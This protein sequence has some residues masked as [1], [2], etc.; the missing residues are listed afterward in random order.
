[1]S[2]PSSAL[3]IP[4]TPWGFSASHVPLYHEWMSSPE[5]REATASEELSVEEEYAMQSEQK[6]ESIRAGFPSLLLTR[7]LTSVQNRGQ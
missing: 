7:A 3:S 5:I 4:L 6:R 2:R 1:M